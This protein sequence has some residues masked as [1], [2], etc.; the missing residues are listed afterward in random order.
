MEPEL[1]EDKLASYGYCT[2]HGWDQFY[3]GKCE[4]CERK[5]KLERKYE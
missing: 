2:R 1:Y 5:I 4:R 3:D